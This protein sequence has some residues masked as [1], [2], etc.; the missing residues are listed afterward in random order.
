MLRP[1]YLFVSRAEIRRTKEGCRRPRVGCWCLPKSPVKLIPMC[2]GC[3]DCLFPVCDC[4]TELFTIQLTLPP[5]ND[6][7]SEMNS[8][9]SIKKLHHP[10]I[11]LKVALKKS[12]FC[13]MVGAASALG[14]PFKGHF[15]AHVQVG[16]VYR[17]AHVPVA[18]KSGSE[19]WWWSVGWEETKHLALPCFLQNPFL[20]ALLGSL[21]SICSDVVANFIH[22]QVPTPPTSLEKNLT[23]LFP[24]KLGAGSSGVNIQDYKIYEL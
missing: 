15:M 7:S 6:P 23:S 22:S 17:Q 1:K 2:R 4:C 16:S 19:F 20:L 18:P 12:N 21:V 14:L 5:P 9:S 8:Y 10:V 11:N 24:E 13:Y 3:S